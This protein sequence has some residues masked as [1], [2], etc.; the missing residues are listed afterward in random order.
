MVFNPLNTVWLKDGRGTLSPQRFTL[1]MVHLAG[2]EINMEIRSPAQMTPSSVLSNTGLSPDTYIIDYL[3][4][5]W[6]NEKI[7]VYIYI[8]I[9]LPFYIQIYFYLFKSKQSIY[10]CISTYINIKIHLIHTYRMR[11]DVY[12]YIYT[13]IYICIYT[14]IYIHAPYQLV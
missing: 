9:L 2:L 14:Y 11:V 6:V 10:K 7:R 1:K 5:C 13:Y 8:Y 4:I 12:I 3:C